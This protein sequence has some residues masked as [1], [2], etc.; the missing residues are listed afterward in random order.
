[1]FLWSAPNSWGILGTCLS[2][3]GI[4]TTMSPR[5]T[6]QQRYPRLNRLLLVLLITAL[7]LRAAHAYVDPNTV[8]PLYQFLFPL[9][10]AVTSTLAAFRRGIVRTCR[11]LVAVLVTIVSGRARKPESERPS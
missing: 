3:A 1:M 2:V 11:R 9:L 6:P 4:R 8:G 10:L 5:A 7:P